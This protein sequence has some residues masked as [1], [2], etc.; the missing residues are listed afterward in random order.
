MPINDGQIKRLEAILKKVAASQAEGGV[1]QQEAEYQNG[2]QW[3]TT[4]IVSRQF[5]ASEVAKILEGE[6]GQKMPEAWLEGCVRGMV[7]CVEFSCAPALQDSREKIEYLCKVII[8]ISSGEDFEPVVMARLAEAGIYLMN[9]DECGIT[10][11]ELSKM[12]QEDREQFF[13]D[14]I[15]K[16][17]AQVESE[18]QLK[19]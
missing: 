6:F 3:S 10:P 18:S 19:H 12:S 2:Y 15:N 9:V 8:G 7:D 13:T 14:F 1:T 17:E 4:R 5:E 16:K 11:E